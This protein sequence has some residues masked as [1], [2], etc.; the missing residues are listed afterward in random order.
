ML[1]QGISLAD[2]EKLAVRKMGPGTIVFRHERRDEWTAE[3]VFNGNRKR[4]TGAG[5][6]ILGWALEQL[7]DHKGP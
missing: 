2:L 3:R 4:V 1:N 5:N 6:R 7:P